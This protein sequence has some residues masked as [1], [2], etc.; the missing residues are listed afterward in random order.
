MKNGFNKFDRVSKIKLDK[1]LSKKK[2][3]EKIG[4]VGVK[5]EEGEKVKIKSYNVKDDIFREA[6]SQES[7][8]HFEKAKLKKGLGIEGDDISVKKR[9]KIMEQLSEAH[10]DDYK[11]DEEEKRAA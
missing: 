4:D 3:A 6:D 9:K 1:K 2:A 7:F 11:E 5:N 10:A 8:D